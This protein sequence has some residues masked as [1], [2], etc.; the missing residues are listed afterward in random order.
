MEL[1]KRAASD[2]V[3]I[4]I[5]LVGTFSLIWLMLWSG[6]ALLFALLYPLLRRIVLGIHPQHG[7]QLLLVYWAA[8]ALV[9]FL[10]SSLLLV[11][12]ADGMFI[13]AHC[14]GAC[15]EHVPLLSVDAL[16]IGGL[17]IAALLILV[18]LFNFLQQLAKG[19][20]M[21]KQ[22][23]L[24]TETRPGYRFLDAVEPAVFTL[25]WWNPRVFISR[26][27]LESCSREQLAV[28]LD[29]EQAHRQRK[30]NL[31]L[32]L[33]RVFTL[34]VPGDRGRQIRHD[35][36]LLCEEACDFVAAGNHG[37]ASVA[38]TLVHVGRVLKNHPAP[39]HSR[40]F[41]CSDL[42]LRVQALLAH[43]GR[44]PIPAWQI[45]LL[46]LVSMSLLILSLDPLHHGAESLI[47]LLE[48][49]VHQLV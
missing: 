32:L 19:R 34:F 44:R 33:G 39:I 38:E 31:R 8:P 21:F 24:M 40:G 47:T 27:L 49:L 11:S 25:G 1:R 15:E 37:V 26:G 14:H 41:A 23:E 42:E 28:I 29:H 7:S 17:V 22:F 2:G 48:Y 9:G 18:L 20:S 6:L 45:L 36:H 3:A 12:R 30:D 10:A 4:M 43:H 16:A 46:T 13:S 5:Q 35:M